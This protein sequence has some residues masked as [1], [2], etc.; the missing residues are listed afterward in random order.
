VP[1]TP[2]WGQ[3]HSITATLTLALVPVHA[4]LRWRWIVSVGK[5]LLP[6]RAVRGPR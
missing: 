3:M 1:R 2:F 4:A 5:R 6:R